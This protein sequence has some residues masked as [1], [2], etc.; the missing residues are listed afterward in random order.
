MRRGPL[1][2]VEDDLRKRCQ[3]MPR[4]Q[5]KTHN[6]MSPGHPGPCGGGDEGGALVCSGNMFGVILRNRCYEDDYEGTAVYLDAMEYAQ[7]ILSGGE[8]YDRA[9]DYDDD[10]YDQ[11]G[12]AGMLASKATI[13][14]LF[15]GTSLFRQWQFE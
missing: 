10:A 15:A 4:A 13:A 12:N 2:R 14:A 7:F 1:R 5:C 6:T 3:K 9:E 8:R 11:D